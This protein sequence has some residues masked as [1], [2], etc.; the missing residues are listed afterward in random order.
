MR[1]ISNPI[2]ILR[3]HVSVYSDVD[4]V[5]VVIDTMITENAM[6]HEILIASF[7]KKYISYVF[8]IR[9]TYSSSGDL[10]S[11]GVSSTAI[12]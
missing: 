6:R 3:S 5:S 11:H 10:R 4:L 7:N 8:S 2:L 1:G 12:M 9:R